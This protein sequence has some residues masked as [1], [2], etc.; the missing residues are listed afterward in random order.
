MASF[1]LYSDESGKLG[2]SDYTSL[3][4]FV[5]HTAEWERISLEWNN[6]RLAWGVPTI[7]MR[8]VMFP[9]RD[10]SREWLAVK[11]EWGG[12]WERKRDD[13]L[14]E[15]AHII[16]R[17]HA[18]CVGS[19]VDA[20]YFEHLPS[21][22]FKQQMQNPLYMSF[23]HS[24][25]TSL[26][27]IDRLSDEHHLSVVLDDDEEYAMKCYQVLNGL[28][29]TFERVRRRIDSICFGNDKAYPALQA[30]DMI[31]YESR[32]LMIERKTDKD[33]EPSKLYAALTRKGV[34]SPHLYT[35]GDLDQLQAN[36]KAV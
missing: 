15:F 19:V 17:S 16:M 36:I 9:E 30:A 34:H 22:P 23:H 35:P 24:V 32:K 12:L 28:R 20:D 5:T 10:K 31:A 27:K 7:H 29:R 25:M 1:L 26:D 18:A 2:N 6:L 33:S 4:G 21:S 11:K 14:D 3:C 8:A 13:M